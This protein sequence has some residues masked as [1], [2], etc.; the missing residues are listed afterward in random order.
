MNEIKDTN[1]D[2]IEKLPLWLRKDLVAKEKDIAKQ[3]GI[4]GAP[5]LI[6]AEFENF[7]WGN[8]SLEEKD[9]DAYSDGRTDGGK[10]NVKSSR[11]RK[12]STC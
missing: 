9:G 6:V 3:L 2:V 4:E 10:T 12:L 8:K 1:S 5:A 7:D 11:P